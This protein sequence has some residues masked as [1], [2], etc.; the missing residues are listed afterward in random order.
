MEDKHKYFYTVYGINLD[1]DIE[2][3]EFVTRHRISEEKN[4]VILGYGQLSEEIKNNIGKGSRIEVSKGNTWFYIEGVATYW[5]E[6]GTSIIVEPCE[7]CDRNLMKI[8]IMGSVLGFL[9]L[10][11]QVLAIHGGTV[12]MDGQ[13]II[14]TGNRGAGKST[15][16]TALGQKGYSFVSDDVA[17]INIESKTSVE[18]GFP[19]HKLCVDALE[20]MNYD[21]EKCIDFKGDGKIK[22]LVI[23]MEGFHGEKASLSAICEIAIGDVEKVEIEEVLGREKFNKII[24]NIYRTEYI[25]RMDGMKPSYFKQ[26]VKVAKDIKFF[27]IT[28][29]RDKY[30]VDEQIQIIEKVFGADKSQRA[31]GGGYL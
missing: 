23:D 12:V 21:K 13:G 17:T 9:L 16:T 19:F 27:K 11:R 26:C 1:S 5:I 28:R 22:Y 20:S 18:P 6:N 31:M 7:H 29:P 14:F 30:T 24:K 4:R 2:V 10:Q 8:Y 25:S 3:V 15:L